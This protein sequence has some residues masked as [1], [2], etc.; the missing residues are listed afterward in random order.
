[1]RFKLVPK[2]PDSL[3]FVADAQRAVPLIPDTEDDCCARLMRR[4][5]FPSRDIARTWLT[6]LRALRLAEETESGFRRTDVDPTREAVREAFVDRVFGASEVLDALE[7][8]GALSADEAFERFKERVP[9]W[10][11]YKNPTEWEDVWRERVERVLDW[12]TLLGAVERTA[13]GRYRR[14]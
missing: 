1:M 14:A 11:H 4:L 2:P 8:D 10:E 6:F 5:D 13:D 12:L 9:T 7:A 3:E